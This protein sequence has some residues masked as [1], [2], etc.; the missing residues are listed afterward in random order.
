MF[1]T[2][3]KFHLI[4]GTQFFE[5]KV[6]NVFFVIDVQLLELLSK[7]HRFLTFSRHEGFYITEMLRNC[8]MQTPRNFGCLPLVGFKRITPVEEDT[9]KF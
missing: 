7:R 1:L 4:V 6:I 9:S 3:Q 8:M 2:D 5:T